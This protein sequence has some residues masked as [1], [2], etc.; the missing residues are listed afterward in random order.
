MSPAVA[1]EQAPS[2]EP[3]VSVPSNSAA[4]V[5]A[6][7]QARRTGKPV[8]VEALKGES[9]DVVAQ[10]DGRLLST[11]YVQPKRVRKAGR[12]WVDVDATLAVLPGGAVA[13]RAA[14]ADIEFSGGGS[15]QPLVRMSRAGKELRLTWPKPLPEPVLEGS[16]AE[17]RSILPDV[18]LKLTASAAGFSQVLV[19]HSAGAAKNPELDALR[20]GLQG[21]GLTVKQEA[22]GSLKA[23]DPVGGGTVFQAPVPVMWDSSKVADAASAGAGPAGAA[24]S[25]AAKSARSKSAAAQAP[26]DSAASAEDDGS[27]PGEGAKMT[28][29]KVDLPKGGMVLTPDRGMLDDPS[30]VYPVMIDPAW[31]TPNASGWAGVS[32]TYPNQT[33]W[34]FT[35]TSTY[36]HDWGV[37][38]CGD[39]SRC[40]PTD[41]KR[42]FFQ[43]PSGAFVGKQI[44]SAEFGT[45]ESH[46]YSCSARPVEL[47]NTGYI[48]SSLTWNK[49]NASGFWS[50]H[51]QDINTA[52]GWSGDCP[53]GWLEFGGNS[54]AVKDLVQDAANWG[55][56]SITFGLKAQNESD[57]LAWKRFTDDAYLRVYYNLAPN[58]IAMSDMTMSPGSVC[59]YD[60]VNIN[61][62]PQVTVNRAT[63]P[64]GE[65][66]AVQ[67]AVN[68]DDGSGLT[69]HWWSTGAENNTPGDFKASGSQF[70]YQLPD[71]FPHNARVS[72]EARSWDGASWGP[73]SS[74][75]DP[76]GCYF[77]VDTTTPSGPTVTSANYPGSTDAT[78]SLPWTDG[79]GKYASFTLKAATTSIT[80]YQWSLDGSP[81][82]DVTT[83]NGAA[84]TVK[85]LPQTPGL[86]I[87]SARAVNAAGTVSQPEAYYFNVLVGQGQRAGWSM[88][89]TSGTS[90]AG[91]GGTFELTPSS[92]ASVTAAGHTGGALALDG[93]T[94]VGG[95]PNGYAETQGAVLDTTQGFTVS[96]WVNIADTTRNRVVVSQNGQQLNRVVLGLINNK[97]TMRTT[98]RDGTGYN[99]Q[100]ATSDAPVV[101]GQWTHLLG[102]Y[103]PVTQKIGLYVNGVAGTPVASAAPWQSSGPLEIGRSKY[104]G[105]W[106]DPWQGSIDDVKLW[107]RPLS[108]ADASKVAAGQP[109]TTGR[110][111]K[112]VWTFDG[113]GT[114]AFTGAGEADALTAYNGAQTG[115]TGN[116]GR[117]G[118]PARGG[119]GGG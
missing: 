64:D 70:T 90:L 34:K 19:V 109:V 7:T 107:D 74:D 49:Q 73:W 38:Y 10:P 61:R 72:W 44:L 56:P 62:V 67:F 41:V 3:T 50:R 47:W 32:R 57:T 14:T 79:V 18:D 95:S 26:A 112:A 68:W 101:P 78:A 63:D 40:A 13:P 113:T 65:A 59:Q 88:D 55:W 48:D 30:T 33:Y 25:G 105:N 1:A 76:T 53:G 93:T 94:T 12:G 11:T 9:S 106:T 104:L 103:D 31:Y 20:L 117:G 80:K 91:T 17:Y 96:A 24:A 45:Y 77:N 22:D 98:D 15:G 69:R 89:E 5:L 8:D 99:T 115:A 118:G 75:G 102:Y 54:G 43:I 81:F 92:G 35:Y 82:T 29:L 116:A 21:D 4:E 27:V 119:G 110:G 66:I 84:Q 100:V 83:T 71:V 51:L 37:G 108:A 85:A 23:V 6:V 46:S 114:T 87:L 52:K 111:A 97:W 28:R 86:H 2:A 36:V 58:Q 60:P 42:A 39:T 16:T